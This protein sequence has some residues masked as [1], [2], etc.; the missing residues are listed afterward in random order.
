MKPG[1]KWRK[2][3]RSAFE[4]VREDGVMRPKEIL[5]IVRQLCRVLEHPDPERSPGATCPIHPQTILVSAGGSVRLSSETLPLSVREAYTPPERDRF[6]IPTSASAVYAIGMSM[7]FMATG[8]EKKADLYVHVEDR[9]LRGLIARCIAFDPQMR[10][11]TIRELSATVKRARRGVKRVLFALPLIV[12]LAAATFVILHFYRDGRAIGEA[13]GRDSG[14]TDGYVSGYE[15]GFSDARGIDI[16]EASVVAGYGNLSGNLAA[17]DGPFAAYSED[18]VFFIY[19]GGIYRMSPYTQTV[20]PLAADAGARELHYHDGWLYYCTDEDVLRVN[21]LTL[22]SEVFCESRTG[23]LYIADGAFFLHDTAGTGYLYRVDEDTGAFTQLNGR[24][25]YRCL[26]IV[27]DKLFFIDADNAGGIYRCDFDG[28]DLRL[29]NS[30][31][32]ESFCIYDGRLYTNAAGF[33]ISMDLDGGNIETYTNIPAYF[34]NVTDGAIFYIAGEDRT[35]EWQ[36][37]NGRVRYTVLPSHTR[38][39]N[40]AGRWIF[41]VN[42]EDGGA[43]W[44]AGIDGSQSKKVT[45]P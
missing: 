10:F 16:G 30:N 41:F 42:E 5:S 2:D 20:R 14:Y 45:V 40:I 23:R 31:R 29:L 9:E 6:D 26:N 37:P 44:R 24:T 32:C 13:A 43:L 39:F 4:I 25:Q 11:T 17:E 34:P 7:L 3:E 35:L 33:L 27:E 18:E 21:P 15:K 36:S 28:G 22:A 1:Y 19:D 12:F 8:Q 38:Q